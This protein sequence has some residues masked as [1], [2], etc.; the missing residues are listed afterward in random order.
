MIDVLIWSKDR[1]CQLELCLRSTDL[2]FK[3]DKC[4]HVIYKASNP[5][6]L[7]GYNILKRLYPNVVFVQE[8]SFA[9]DTKQ[10]LNSMASSHVL[11]LTDDDI[12]INPV[13][14]S[15][16]ADASYYMLVHPEVHALSF[17]MNPEINYCYPAKKPM[18]IPN[19]ISRDPYLL[20]NWKEQPDPHTCWGYPCA[21]NG[22]LYDL[23]WFRST[24]SGL[25]FHNANTLECELNMC[26]RNE[27]PQLMSFTQTK[28]FNVQ[29]NFVQGVY[30]TVH[31]PG[32]TV[33][34]LNKKLLS[35]E[36]ITL[37][38][39]LGMK[40]TMAHGTCD[41][42]F[43]PYTT[44]DYIHSYKN[45]QGM[46]TAEENLRTAM[47]K[48]DIAKIA[49]RDYL[50][51]SWATNIYHIQSEILSHSL[52][53]FLTIPTLEFTMVI[54]DALERDVEYSAL[55]KREDFVTRVQSLLAAPQIGGITPARH[56]MTSNYPTIAQTYH[57]LTF[58]DT[59]KVDLTK[60]DYILEF[61]GGY[62]NLCSIIHRAGFKGTYILYD[63]E[64]LLLIQ[65]Y[66]LTVS[67]LLPGVNVRFVS[68]PEELYRELT[69]VSGTGMFV[70][71]WAFNEAPIVT[72][73]AILKTFN[74][75][76]YVYL[77]Y[78]HTFDGIN[79]IDWFENLI[80][81]Y[82]DINW[83]NEDIAYL[84]HSKYLF[85]TKKPKN[86]V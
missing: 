20:W 14:S 42:R 6:F 45:N 73:D 84:G 62:G 37:T 63:I 81:T 78:N 10:I 83:F 41:Y 75:Y 27:K 52:D 46:S 76:N 5:E 77:I 69:N 47:S 17:R 85:G 9:E 26:R 56:N 65:E 11:C 12:F 35:G 51:D 48:L 55:Q 54:G 72:R 23:N 39:I 1:A 7:E 67:K 74:R 29:N 28:I 36:R 50:S 22:H 16:L 57:L 80:S 66:F 32:C 53:T 21:I 79:N 24:I 33:E 13:E 64:P 34:D 43:E 59:M 49:V 58:T 19:F 18:I 86:P 60:V 82:T 61:G 3:A 70:S 31:T 15:E 68:T 38:G 44:L 4:V 40:T 25:N 8:S 30:Q 71:T 2:N